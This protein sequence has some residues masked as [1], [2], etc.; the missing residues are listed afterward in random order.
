MNSGLNLSATGFCLGNARKLAKVAQAVYSDVACDIS[1]RVTDTHASVAVYDDCTVIAFRGTKD[2]RN[3]ITDAEFGKVHYGPTTRVHRGFFAAVDSV[4]GE[5]V[6]SQLVG[7]R[8]A[9]DLPLGGTGDGVGDVAPPVGTAGRMPASTA[10]GTPA[11]T[12]L[13]LTGR[14]LGGAVGGGAD[15]SPGAGSSGR[16]SAPSLPLGGT[17]DG[18][19]DARR[20]TTTDDGSRPAAAGSPTIAPEPCIGCGISLGSVMGGGAD[21]S[22]G[23]G[24]SGRRSAPSLPLV[25]TG[26][27]LGGALAVLAA[28]ILNAQ[29]FLIHSVYTFGQPRVG[30]ATF[31]ARY[32][33]TLGQRTF[34]IVNSNDLVPRLPGWLMGYRHCGQHFFI[35]A[36]GALIFN[37][38]LFTLLTTDF[39]G[40][41]R[42]YRKLD[43]VVIEDHFMKRYIA[44]L[45]SLKNFYELACPS[46]KS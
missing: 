11:A 31:A 24:S 14:S 5:I 9:A 34:R 19:D 23:A 26:H 25:V 3:W 32:N 29:G 39:V 12:P 7:P 37:P 20:G 41:Y 27:S 42:A 6:Q 44:A 38:S 18:V 35:T 45:N 13:V 33:M 15:C 43:G 8:D 21:C 1:N 4:I 17:G 46:P 10:G 28:D 16:R 22:P 40:L 2:L 30:D 36:A